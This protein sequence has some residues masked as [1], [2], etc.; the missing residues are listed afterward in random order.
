MCSHVNFVDL[1]LCERYIILAGLIWFLPSVYLHLVFE[2]IFLIFFYHIG[3][4]ISIDMVLFFYIGILSS[5]YMDS[6][7]KSYKYMVSFHVYTRLSILYINIYICQISYVQ[8][9]W[10]CTKINYGMSAA[11][12]PKY[13]L[14]WLHWLDGFSPGFSPV[15]IH[16]YSLV[17]I[18]M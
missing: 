8:L 16:R 13:W 2:V 11:F 10:L 15:C 12:R 6:L 3:C 14:N 18:H 7:H 1:F 4:I 5:V 9:K 17:C